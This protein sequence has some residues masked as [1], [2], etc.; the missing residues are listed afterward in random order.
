MTTNTLLIN[1]LESALIMESVSVDC[2][3]FGLEEGS[4]RVLL[5]Q[6]DGG[7]KDG[8]WALPG[9]YVHKGLSLDEMPH[10]VLERLTGLKDVYV[11]QF[12]SFGDLTRVDF[13]RV[14][15]IAY[16]A[17]ISTKNHPLVTG[18]GAKSAKWYKMNEVP[19]LIYDHNAILGK[20]IEKL[21]DKIRKEPI[22]FELLPE[23]FTLTQ[24]QKVYEAILDVKL[25]TRNFR[26][27]IQKTKLIIGLAERDETVPYRA[28]QL[29]RFDHEV[30]NELVRTGYYFEI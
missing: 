15:T 12:G 26:K 24:L 23:K 17:L 18:P 11:D 1:P 29:Y 2:V 8:M 9:D 3:I 6:H 27:K 21:R 19:T 22:G 13:K 16:F 7:P 20:G 10:N 14:I 25:D 4:L 5:V 30:Y 28:P